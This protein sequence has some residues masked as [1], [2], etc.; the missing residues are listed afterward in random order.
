MAARSGAGGWVVCWCCRS[1]AVAATPVGCPHAGCLQHCPPPPPPPPSTLPSRVRPPAQRGIDLKKIAERMGGASGAELKA[2]CTEAGMFAL[3]ERRVHVTQVGWHLCVHVGRGSREGV[4]LLPRGG[5][6]WGGGGLWGAA[7]APPHHA[8]VC[9]GMGRARLHAAS[10]STH[11]CFPLHWMLPPA[12]DAPLSQPS[13]TRAL[14]S[15]TA[16]PPS[17]Q[18]RPPSHPPARLPRLAHTLPSLLL[19]LHPSAGGF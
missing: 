8:S 2:V 14:W 4:D 3:R 12:L 9:G 16:A 5:A 15:C 11:C 1:I 6:G 17:L 10:T 19:C 7:H 13:S 18:K